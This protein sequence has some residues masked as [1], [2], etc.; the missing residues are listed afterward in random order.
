ML[1]IQ[2][3]IKLYLKIIQLYNMIIN[4]NA[5]NFREWGKNKTFRKKKM[6]TKKTKLISSDSKMID[7]TMSSQYSRILNF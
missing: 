7:Y 1:K 6:K 4:K 2:A 3:N 5:Y